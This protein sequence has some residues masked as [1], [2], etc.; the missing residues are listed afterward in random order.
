M[1]VLVHT[2]AYICVCV[3]IYIYIYL[4]NISRYKEIMDKYTLQAMMSATLVGWVEP[5]D[6]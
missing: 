3:Y 4:F 2:Y 5:M 6:L 1:C